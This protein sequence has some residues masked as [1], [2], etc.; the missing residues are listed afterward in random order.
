MSYSDGINITYEVTGMDFT[1]G[2]AEDLVAHGP[3]RLTGRVKSIALRVT[4]GI[5]V[6]ASTID[7]GVPSGDADAYA[8]V[9]APIA[10]A[11][12]IHGGTDLNNDI[13]EGVSGNRIPADTTFAIG[14]GGGSTAGVGN[15]LVTIEWS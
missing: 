15:V 14:N 5:T 6:A 12:E 1:A 13:T 4:T 7:V 11:E 3:P 8:T 2:A 10:A 9:A